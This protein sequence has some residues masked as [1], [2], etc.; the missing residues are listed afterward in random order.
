MIKLVASLIV[1][2]ITV[3]ISWVLIWLGANKLGIPQEITGVFGFFYIFMFGY[4]WT[5]IVKWISV[6]LKVKLKLDE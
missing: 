6:K 2:L 1:G 3:F 4:N 5:A